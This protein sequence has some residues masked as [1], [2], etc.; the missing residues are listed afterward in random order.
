MEIR[1]LEIGAL[2]IGALEIGAW[3]I[4]AWEMGAGEDRRKGSVDYRRIGNG[5]VEI[6]D[7]Q[8]VHLNPSGDLIF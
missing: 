3:E 7:P 8:L 2:E 1:A 6:L 5:N 4:G